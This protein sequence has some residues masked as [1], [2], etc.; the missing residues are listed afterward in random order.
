MQPAAAGIAEAR[1]C[2]TREHSPPDIILLRNDKILHP[3]VP[4]KSTQICS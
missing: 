2:Q 3:K 1:L 4:L